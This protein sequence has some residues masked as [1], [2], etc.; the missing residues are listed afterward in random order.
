M[1]IKIVILIVFTVIFSCAKVDKAEKSEENVLPEEKV[2]ELE[3]KI[4]RQNVHLYDHDFDQSSK[5]IG[6]IKKL[7]PEIFVKI[8]ILYRKEN[9]KWL[10]ESKSLPSNEQQIYIEK[11]H[12]SFFETFGIT[13]E[14]YIHYSQ[15][16]IDELNTYMSEHQELLSELQD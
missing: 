4:D 2:D 10:E 3:K 5:E 14:E 12:K 15:N 1:V 6:V 11:A 8:T 13:E 7:S 16:N 9:K